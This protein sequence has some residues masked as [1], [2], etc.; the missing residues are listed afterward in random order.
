MASY[1][2]GSS[3]MTW[4][5]E[6]AQDPPQ[7]PE[8]RFCVRERVGGDRV[9]REGVGRMGTDLPFRDLRLGR[10]PLG[11]HQPRP[12]KSVRRRLCR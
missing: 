2:S 12:R 9:Q 4:Q 1:F 8:G 10:C 7:A 11:Y 3:T 5:V 6:Q